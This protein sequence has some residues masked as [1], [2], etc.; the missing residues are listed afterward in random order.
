VLSGIDGASMSTAREK[1]RAVA[2]S[3]AE[4]DQ[5]RLR[6]YRFDALAIVP[7]ANPVTLDNVT[8]TIKSEASWITDDA[9]AVPACGTVAQKQAEYLRIVSTVTSNIVGSR[10]APVKIESMVAPSVVYGQD[11]GTLAV[12]VLDRAGVGVPGI[13]VNAKSDDGTVL[14][15]QVTNDAGCAL[16]RSVPV[17]GYTVG[18]NTPGYISKAGK[19][20]LETTTTVNP[21]YI[22]NVSLTYDRKV[23]MTVAVKTLEPGDTF[24]PTA[25]TAVPS[26]A[27]SVSDAAADP[28]VLRTFTPT[29]PTVWANSF[30]SPDLFPYYNSPYSYFTG[31]C[32]YMSPTKAATGYSTYFTTIN[33]LAAVQGDPTVFQPQGATVFQPALNLRIARDSAGTAINAATTTM[34]VYVK[35]TKPSGS[36]DTCVSDYSNAWIPLALKDWPAAYGTRPGGSSAIFNFAW[37]NTAG[38][39]AG[40]PF[41]TYAVCIVD[42]ARTKRSTTTYDNTKPSGPTS[43][44]TGS[45]TQTVELPATSGVSWSNTTACP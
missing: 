23:N 2:G 19:Q 43:T 6:S 27:M 36:T 32:I 5:E 10:I 37:Q 22:N 4:Q 29:A 17:G 14:P 21:N 12:R 3:L 38:Y 34:K 40:M 25:T 42:T 45:T 44:P 13:V 24:S 31:D 28:T 33:T 26:Q 41:G 9:N 20:L 30:A 8:Y 11:H 15:S 16:F 18:V 35:L 7:Q 1:A 39:D